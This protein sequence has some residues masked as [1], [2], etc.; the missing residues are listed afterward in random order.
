[1]PTLIDASH[2]VLSATAS[3]R[4][5]DGHGRQRH[6]HRCRQDTNR[7][8]GTRF[9]DRRG[10][11]P[12]PYSYGSD[13]HRLLAVGA[14]GR[15]YDANGN[16][17]RRNLTTRSDATLGY[18]ERNRL[19]SVA[20][21]GGTTRY[22]HNA[23]GERVYKQVF[24]KTSRYAF[25]EAG[26]ILVED[27]SAAGGQVQE[28]LWLDDLPVGLLIGKTLYL[29]QPDHL[30]SPRKVTTQ[31]LAAPT[32]LWSW[33]ILDNP[34]GEFPP[35]DDPNLNG[36]KFTLNLRFPG[37]QYDPE[38]GLHYNTFRDYEPGVGRYVESDPIGLGGGPSTFGYSLQN[39][40]VYFDFD[41]LQVAAGALGDALG[42]GFGA[43]G[44]LGGATTHSDNDVVCMLDP[45]RCVEP[46]PVREV[47]ALLYSAA[48]I[49]VNSGFFRGA[50]NQNSNDCSSCTDGGPP[51][52]SKP[53]DQTPWSGDHGK[54]KSE[55]GAGPRDKVKIGP[56]PNEDVW[57]QNPNGSWT[58]HGPAGIYTGSGQPAGRRGKDRG[59]R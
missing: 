28:F 47:C 3:P 35:D 17:T 53:I 11:L 33:P 10:T 27:A 34:F 22:R 54:I 48:R 14:S 26:R 45:Q 36:S 31:K 41:G 18:D 59:G 32:L 51:P 55:V 12:L 19:V 21:S 40:G 13:S 15:S 50:I 20:S 43:G 23:R 25:D 42:G 39:P 44:A 49:L 38:T 4:R 2:R 16:T 30:G 6:A 37:Q 56:P 9:G 8:P 1:M 58:N 52:G 7:H 46:D 29:I 5:S 57:V 24:G